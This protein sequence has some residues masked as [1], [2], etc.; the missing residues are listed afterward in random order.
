MKDLNRYVEECTND[1]ESLGIELGN[2]VE[3]FVNTRAKRRWG[4]CSKRADGFHINISSDLLQDDVS[5]DAIKNT[6]AHELLHTIKGGMKHTGEWKSAAELLN[7]IYGYNI[8]RVTTAEE[9]GIER[10]YVRRP[11]KYLIV[12]SNCN[13]VYRYQKMTK[14]VQRIQYGYKSRYKCGY[15][16]KWGT[17]EFNSQ[18]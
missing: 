4:Q 3:V 18:V 5:D 16:N 10:E 7:D 2:I 12:C 15:C 13:Y 17:L 8:K 9:K 6:V 14:T 11:A 1:I